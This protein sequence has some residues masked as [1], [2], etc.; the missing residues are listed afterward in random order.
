MPRWEAGWAGSHPG[1]ML[2]AQA[3]LSEVSLLLNGTPHSAPRFATTHTQVCLGTLL[4]HQHSEP[5][6]A[7]ETRLRE[8][9]ADSDAGPGPGPE[10]DSSSPG[11]PEAAG[12]GCSVT[13]EVGLGPGGFSPPKA[14]GSQPSSLSCSEE[15]LRGV[16]LQGIMGCLLISEGHWYVSEVSLGTGP[17][18]KSGDTGPSPTPPHSEYTHNGLGR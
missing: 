7:C 9:L 8:A 14:P 18:R 3:W 6:Q 17:V 4:S 2:L 1:T 11:S 15:P 16:P 10:A 13:W 5:R 12:V